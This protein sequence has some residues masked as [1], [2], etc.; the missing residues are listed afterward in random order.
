LTRIY[1][2]FFAPNS[3][4]SQIARVDI[5]Q[6]IAPRFWAG[7]YDGEAATAQI[8]PAWYDHI[9]LGEFPDPR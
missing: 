7:S 3:I 1:I 2:F 8:R 5:N 9:P 4:G 6:E